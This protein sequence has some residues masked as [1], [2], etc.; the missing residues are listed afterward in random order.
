ME[1]RYPLTRYV[2]RPLSV[3]IAGALAN[4][5]VTPTQVTY[6]SAA[7]SFGGGFAFGFDAF[8]LGAILTLLGSITDCVDGD[9]ARATSTTSKSGSYLDHVFDRWTDAAL[10]VGLTFS[11]LSNLGAIGFAAL[12]GTFMTSYARTKSQAVGTDASVGLGSRDAR[13]LI[14]VVAGLTGFIMQGLIVVAVLGGI[15]AIHRMAWTIN[16]LDRTEPGREKTT[17]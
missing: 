4:T 7:L 8:V 16:E 2:Y 12:I 9:L 5:R 14:L 6:L 10:I 1:L 13:M 17:E 3:P 15:T 11:D